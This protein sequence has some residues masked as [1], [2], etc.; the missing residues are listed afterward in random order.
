MRILSPDD[1]Q[2]YSAKVLLCIKRKAKSSQDAWIGSCSDGA[3]GSWGMGQER[4]K[5]VE[6][7]SLIHSTSHYRPSHFRA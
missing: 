7:A 1:G 5:L 6:N 3:S 4:H 2:M